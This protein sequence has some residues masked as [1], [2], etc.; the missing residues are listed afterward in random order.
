MELVLRS[1]AGLLDFWKNAVVRVRNIV[2]NVIGRK[3]RR[4]TGAF[5]TVF[6]S[7]VTPI[8]GFVDSFQ[9]PSKSA[10]DGWILGV[11]RRTGDKLEKGLNHLRYRGALLPSVSLRAVD[12]LGIDAQRQLPSHTPSA[13]LAQRVGR[14]WGHMNGRISLLI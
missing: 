10:Q 6:F 5:S 11:L 2:A 4:R 14:M 12:H 13:R 3:S 8:A 9:R 1:A 7:S